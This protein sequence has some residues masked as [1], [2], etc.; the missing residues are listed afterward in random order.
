[1][2]TAITY[3]SGDFYFGRNLDLEYGYNET[4]TITPRNYPFHFRCVPSM[5]THFAMIGMAT[6][7]DE[8]PL[9]YEATNEKGLS[10][11]GLNFPNL[12]AYLPMNPQKVNVAPFEFI[13]W[14]LGQASSIE[15]V[16]NL[17]ADLNLV[18]IPSSSQLPP[19]PLHWIISDAKASLVIEPMEDGL[20]IH[21]NPIGVLTNAPPFDYHLYHLR[22]YMS[23]SPNVVVS[24]F[25]EN[26]EMTPF[27][28]GM[29]AM[30]LPGDWSSTSRF[31]R[32]AFIKLNSLS[33]TTE[34]GNVSQF[35]HIL[36]AVS[37]PRGS[38]RVKDGIPD[39][40]R[41]SCCINASQGIYYY[42]TYDNCQI[43]ALY[44]HRENLNGI[45]PIS[46]PLRTQL[47]IQTETQSKGR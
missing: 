17:L 24:R 43:T 7:I 8:F 23:L 22:Q 28:G 30:G 19:T 45:A 46:Y 4:I 15:D 38:V 3:N 6:V 34:P 36:S 26:Y 9:Y 39:I 10:M 37:M 40:T 47:Q 42:T 1:M 20:H 18:N 11:A 21:E 13:P 33:D 31:V 44:L 35:F 41:Y 12:A 29:D 16:R 2:C 27:S 32:A 25:S 14:V 5:A